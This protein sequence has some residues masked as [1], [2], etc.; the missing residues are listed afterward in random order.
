M[1][2][3]KRAHRHINPD[4]LSEYVDGRIQ[5]TELAR[6]DDQLAACE[7]CREEV[8]SLRSMV[9]MLRELPQEAPSRSFIMAAPPPMPGESPSSAFQ[10]SNWLRV[11]QWAYAGAASV[12]V[13]V[14]VALVSADASG[15]LSPDNALPV[16][17]ES[18]AITQEIEP[19]AQ[20]SGTPRTV[21]TE[22]EESMRTLSEPTSAGKD[23]DDSQAAAPAVAPPMAAAAPQAMTEDTPAQVAAA[24]VAA[25]G[26]AEPEQSLSAAAAQEFPAQ[27][28]SPAQASTQKS[29]S[30]EAVPPVSLSAEAPPEV[31]KL[32]ATAPVTTG[33]PLPPSEGT[34][35]VWRVLEGVAGVLG[36]I[37]LLAL[38]LK[39][40]LSNNERRN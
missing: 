19:Q 15:L 22:N 14:L 13:I 30:E 3:I 21:T 29:T 16:Q 11:P 9:T 31:D 4:T 6:I 8:A 33:V 7:L 36:V 40:R 12:A 5:G 23:G 27:E 25:A 28:P 2:I 17:V 24:P 37:F 10:L 20:E 39:W 26:E 35:A 32:P 38:G 1:R 18:A 34:A